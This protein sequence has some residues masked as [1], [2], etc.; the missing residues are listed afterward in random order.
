M[1]EELSDVL[2]IHTDAYMENVH[3]SISGKIVS[4]DSI[5]RK[6][7]V[8]P[9][10][11]LKTI[12]EV[13]VDLPVIDNVPVMFPSGSTFVLK[14]DIK[15]GDGCLLIFSEVGL[16]NYLNGNGVLQVAT[17][18]SS[19][20]DLTDA[21]CIPGLFP[22]SV[23]KT[24]YS[25]PPLAEIDIT[26]GIIGLNGND[27]TFMTYTEFNT[28]LQS[29]IIALNAKFATKKDEAG[30]AGGL[31]LDISLSETTTIKTGG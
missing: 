25:S 8:L 19:R 7:S 1:K 11:K 12:K 24:M 14:W 5:E 3:T 28:A 18:D 6:A 27:K 9:L 15:P 29:F 31:S 22:F 16:G 23:S 20:F 13:N 26:N 4:Y 2:E 10:I 21:I 17:E 30:S